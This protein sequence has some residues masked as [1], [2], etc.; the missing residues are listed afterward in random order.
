MTRKLPKEAFHAQFHNHEKYET[1]EEHE[2]APSDAAYPE[3]TAS[4]HP[5]PDYSR[6]KKHHH[7]KPDAVQK[8]LHITVGR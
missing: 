6:K 8:A 5:N 1:E 3:K 7:R 2:Y 4:R